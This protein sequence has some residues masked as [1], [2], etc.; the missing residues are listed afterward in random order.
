[1]EYEA[2]E[3]LDYYNNEECFGLLYNGEFVICLCCG[4]IFELDD[5]QIIRH[6][7]IQELIDFLARRT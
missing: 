1:M 4:S 3:F 7:T 6:I 2:I 5:I